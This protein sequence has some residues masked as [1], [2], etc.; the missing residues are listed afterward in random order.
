MVV[1]T[2][3]VNVVTSMWRAR[4]FVEVNL[5]RFMVVARSRVGSGACWGGGGRLLG[6]GKGNVLSGAGGVGA[7]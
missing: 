4:G 2:A 7:R 1:L 5:S 6:G 3:L